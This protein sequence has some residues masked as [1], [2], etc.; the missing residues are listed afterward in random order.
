MS[1]LFSLRWLLPND[2][3]DGDDDD[4]DDDDDDAQCVKCEGEETLVSVN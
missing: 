2:D 4:D 3:G 1:S